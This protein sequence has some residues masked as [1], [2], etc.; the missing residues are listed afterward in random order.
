MLAS[1]QLHFNEM[2][3]AVNVTGYDVV[4]EVCTVSQAGELEI[5]ACNVSFYFSNVC[6]KII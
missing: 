4:A 3:T 5:S 6:N 1:R 2:I